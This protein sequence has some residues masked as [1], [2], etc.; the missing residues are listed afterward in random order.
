MKGV[1]EHVIM[2]ITWDNLELGQKV[3]ERERKRTM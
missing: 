3:I 2:E 1:L